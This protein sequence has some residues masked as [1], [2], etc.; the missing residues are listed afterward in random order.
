MIG[1]VGKNKNKQIGWKCENMEIIFSMSSQLWIY[2]KECEI[3]K[4]K[5]G[6]V[7]TDKQ[8]LQKL[9]YAELFDKLSNLS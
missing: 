8:K 7:L 4:Y 1:K 3:V 9:T 2:I 6:E 5:I